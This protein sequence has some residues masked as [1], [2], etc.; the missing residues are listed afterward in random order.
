[1]VVFL[2][3]SRR[4]LL[5]QRRRAFDRC[6]EA[7]HEAGGDGAID[8]LVVCSEAEGHHLPDDDLSSIDHGFL[9]TTAYAEYAALGRIKYRGES[10]HRAEYAD[11][12]GAADHVVG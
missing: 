6:L 10:V 7:A 11:G 8:H 5:E 4:A 2:W 3:P 9:N 1:M 12:E